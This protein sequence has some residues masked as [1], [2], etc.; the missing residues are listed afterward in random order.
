MKLLQY[1]RDDLLVKQ[2]LEKGDRLN[3]DLGG[4]AGVVNTER[5]ESD[6]NRTSSDSEEE[7]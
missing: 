4:F 7:V 6:N 3:L 2:M 5:G 1:R